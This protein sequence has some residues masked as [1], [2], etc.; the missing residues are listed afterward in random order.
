MKLNTRE[1]ERTGVAQLR[2]EV[3]RRLVNSWDPQ[4]VEADRDE[5]TRGGPRLGLEIGLEDCS[6]AL[7]EQCRGP[8]SFLSYFIN[9]SRAVFGSLLLFYTPPCLGMFLFL[10]R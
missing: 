8:A 9:K 10:R 1:D 5:N 4:K 2:A 6:L 3:G 7:G